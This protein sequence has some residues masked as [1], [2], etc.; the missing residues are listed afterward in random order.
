MS[1]AWILLIGYFIGFFVYGMWLV[2]DKEIMM[3][4]K[5]D[6]EEDHDLSMVPEN[7]LKFLCFGSVIVVS[8]FWPW[9]IIS[10]PFKAF[11]RVLIKGKRGNDK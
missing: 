10:A 5:H 2:G 7:L 4:F 1:N 6:L 3:E 8:I 11:Y 9:H